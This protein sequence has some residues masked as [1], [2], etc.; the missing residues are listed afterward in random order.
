LRTR[1]DD[2]PQRFG[3]G[4]T[5]GGHEEQCQRLIRGDV[6][7]TERDR[8]SK[9]RFRIGGSAGSPV[10][11]SDGDE[12][13]GRLR[14]Q[15]HG[16]T[17]LLLAARRVVQPCERLGQHEMSIRVRAVRLDSRHGAIACVFVPAGE[18][19]ERSCADLSGRIVRFQFR[20]TKD[21]AGGGLR[22]L[23]AGGRIGELFV[24]FGRGRRDLDRVAV[25]DRR[26]AI[27]AGARERVAARDVLAGTRGRVA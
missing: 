22:I 1:S 13:L 26:L 18:Q 11:A 5:P 27:F 19:I 20:H 2:S 7:R 4:G 24:R 6:L 17:Q 15:P 3:V 16:F 14:R 23:R 9:C 10:K 21:G 8:F 25:L 12:R